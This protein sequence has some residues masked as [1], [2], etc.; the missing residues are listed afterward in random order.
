MRFIYLLLLLSFSSS[1]NAQSDT[2]R[3]EKMNSGHFSA[4]VL[5]QK[6]IDTRIM[7]ESGI[8]FPILDSTFVSG[9]KKKININIIPGNISMNLSG[10]KVRCYHQTTDTLFING[11][12]HTDTTLIANLSRTDIDMLYPIQSFINPIDSSRIIELDISGSFM[13]YM[14]HNELSQVKEQYKTFNM[15]NEDYGRMYSF[16]TL[17][18]VTDTMG[19]ISKLK[20][21]FI[22]DLGNPMFLALFENHPDVKDFIQATSIK[23]QQGY[24]KAGKPMPLKVMPVIECAFDNDEKFSDVVFITTS[25]YSNLKSDG[26]LGLDFLRR[27]NVIFDFGD[28]KIYLKRIN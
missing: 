7:L 24:N 9:N 12:I 26:F 19:K 11:Q 8:P 3:I 28:K 16:E 22:P 13:R 6:S 18:S 17:L 10:K 15:Q 5:L 4:R 27:F 1:L 25:T 20:A 14:S 23:L 2:I 21:R